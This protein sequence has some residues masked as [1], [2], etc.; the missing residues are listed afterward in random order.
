M[1]TLFPVFALLSLFLAQPETARAQE[2]QDFLFVG[3]HF[4]EILE[5]NAA[6]RH[7]GLA[8]D[9]L[10]RISEATGDRF[11]IRM[12]PWKRAQTMVQKGVAD[13]LIGPYKT[14]AREKFLHYSEQA[15]YEDRMVFI[16]RRD[17]AFDWEGDFDDLRGLRVVTVRGWAYGEEFE[18]HLDLMRPHISNTIFLGMQML[19]NGRADLLAGNE[20]NALEAI[21]QNFAKGKVVFLRPPFH[22]MTGYFGFSRAKPALAMQQRF[23]KA[24]GEIVTSGEL[25]RLWAAY[26]LGPAEPAVTD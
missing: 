24:L 20:R 2:K 9:I 23:N 13:A 5:L 8:V 22:W 21:H 1:K 4:A 3:T 15:F 7:R 25:A 12:L 16:A 14:A 10:E 26:G 18:N 11:E 17:E 19:L 6:G